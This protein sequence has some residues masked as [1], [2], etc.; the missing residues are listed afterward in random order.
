MNI[1]LVRLRLIGDVVFTTPVVRALRR[2]YPEA[3]ITYLV[4]ASAAPVL[5]GNP[6][7]DELMVVPKR[8]GV[9]RVRDDI[10]IAVGL[11]RR[12]FD[13]AIDLHGGPRSAWLTWASGAP[14]RIGYTIKGRSWMYTH[15]VAR[16]ADLAPRHSVQNQWDLLGPLGTPD[17]DPARDPVEMVEDGAAASRLDRRLREAGIRPDDPLVM[18]HVSANNP[19][20]RWPADSFSSVVA[21]LARRDHTRRIVVFSGPS[22]AAAAAGITAQARAALGDGGAAVPDIGGLDVSEIRALAGRAAVYIGGDSGPIHIAATTRVPI[23]AIVGPTLAERSRPWRDPRLFSEVIDGG[24]L[25]CRPCHQRQC[26]PGDFRCLTG[27]SAERVLAAA[28]R[29]MQH[30]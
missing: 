29:G 19:F 7:L 16:A 6:H 14:R 27:V 15:V 3:H 9:G 20:R 4:E 25:P 18:V 12:R 1:L 24:P 23:V 8:S 22:D 21:E 11:R 28:E 26:V 17:P 30:A 2:T 10:A 5:R 13:L